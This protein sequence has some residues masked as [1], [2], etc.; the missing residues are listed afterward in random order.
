M[1]VILEKLGISAGS[2]HNYLKWP[3][4][5]TAR[6]LMVTSNW[7][8][9]VI[10]RG[11]FDKKVYFTKPA[12]A[13]KKLSD[14]RESRTEDLKHCKEQ[15]IPL[16]ILVRFI[17]FFPLWARKISACNICILMCEKFVVTF[18]NRMYW[19]KFEPYFATNWTQYYRVT[20]GNLTFL[21]R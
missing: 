14:D 16:P 8:L 3:E 13:E 1:K 19:A 18:R 20:N 9:S 17:D 12:T 21:N 10:R 4:H 7:H 5:K 15:K 2:D 6:I 11:S